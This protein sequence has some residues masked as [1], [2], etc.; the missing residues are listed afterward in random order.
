MI[1]SGGWPA[2][3]VSECTRLIMCT[4]DWNMQ[5]PDPVMCVQG[6]T[7]ITSIFVSVVFR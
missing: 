4:Q 5:S 6:N 3:E 1:K 2:T 7:K